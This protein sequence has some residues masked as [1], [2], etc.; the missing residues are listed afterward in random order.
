MPA[1]LARALDAEQQSWTKN[2]KEAL[3]AARTRLGEGSKT[4]QAGRHQDALAIFTQAFE[5]FEDILVQARQGEETGDSAALEVGRE[6]IALQCASLIAQAIETGQIDADT[7][8]APPPSGQ[9]ADAQLQQRRLYQQAADLAERSLPPA[10]PMVQLTRNFCGEC[11]VSAGAEVD[12]AQGQHPRPAGTPLGAAPPCEPTD[13]RMASTSV[14]L[15]RLHSRDVLGPLSTP[16]ARESH[17]HP[18][19]ATAMASTM[20]ANAS[21]GASRPR[22]PK[23]PAVRLAK[24]EA[25][26]C[27]AAG[28]AAA[29]GAAGATA[30]H[31]RNVGAPA[32]PSRWASKATSKNTNMAGTIAKKRG[33]HHDR[34]GENQDIFAEFIAEDRF[35]RDTCKGFFNN[36]VDDLTKHVREQARFVKLQNVGR[37]HQ[38]L[39]DPRYSTYGHKLQLKQLEQKNA[40]RSEPSLLREARKLGASPEVALVRQ[41]RNTLDPKVL[42]SK[43]RSTLASPGM[44]LRHAQGT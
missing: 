31:D 37:D 12:A 4:S 20:P 7:D 27:A 44:A 9:G 15:P 16:V 18:A 11:D 19:A 30:S 23:L 21:I 32:L 33:G 35:E 5:A 3:E 24:A 28:A 10:H 22:H 34:R 26:P 6:A 29:G 13:A 39:S 43:R 42:A 41:L 38:T 14:C 17:G 1:V 2:M 8:D 36:R 40:T 25:Q